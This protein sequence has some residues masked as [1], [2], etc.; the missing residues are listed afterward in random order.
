MKAHNPHDEEQ[1]RWY[2]LIGLGIAGAYYLCRAVVLAPYKLMMAFFY[3]IALP[4]K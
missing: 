2:H 3:A 4:E 1:F